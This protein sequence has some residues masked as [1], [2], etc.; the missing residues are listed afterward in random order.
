[1]MRGGSWGE[2]RIVSES[3]VEESTSPVVTG[4]FYGTGYGYMWWV[5]V[6]GRH[7]PGV[8]LPDGSFIARG[9]GPHHMLVAPALDLVV[10][11]MAETNRPR[12]TNWVE[13]DDV[14]RMFGLV[15]EA[16]GFDALP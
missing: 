2:R 15:L 14:A 12:P 11:H 16:R 5:P 8:V 3:W 9:V 6:E 1:M 10:V 7:Y 4:A 13:V